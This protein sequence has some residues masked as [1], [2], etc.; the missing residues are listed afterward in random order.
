MF[1]FGGKVVVIS[2]ESV[3]PYDRTAL[4]TSFY[5]KDAEERFL[6]RDPEYFTMAGIDIRLDEEVYSI[7]PGSKTVA[8]A[9]GS[10]YPYDKLLLATGAAARHL[11]V[12]GERLPGVHHIRSFDD[13]EKLRHAFDNI[14]SLIILGAGFL[15]LEIGFTAAARGIDVTVAAPELLPLQSTFGERY[16]QRV[17]RLMEAAGIRW[18]GGKTTRC[19]SGSTELDSVVFTDGSRVEAD[20]AVVAVGSEPSIPFDGIETLITGGGIRVRQDF[21]TDEP[22]IFAAGDVAIGDADANGISVHAGHWVTAMRQGR[23]A[24][25]AMLGHN[26]ARGEIPF[27]WTELG[28]EIVRAVGSC[29]VADC[30]TVLKQGDF[31]S[32]NFLAV[33]ECKGELTGAFAVGYD[34]ELID[35]EQTLRE[36]TRR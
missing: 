27:F 2:R 3:Y 19:F 10:T 24:A 9:S 6:L 18:L 21:T 34:R 36:K 25:Q 8:C 17:A 5:T 7:N 1:G 23:V 14:R 20:A 32:G 22:E 29:A 13:A 12:D 4:T 28:G 11:G 33:W 16:A 26:G 15:G 30:I 31:E 35:I